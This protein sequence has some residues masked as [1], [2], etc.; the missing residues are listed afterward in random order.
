MLKVQNIVR[1]KYADAVA[2]LDTRFHGRKVLSGCV[3]VRGDN[4]QDAEVITVAT[5][6][7]LFCRVR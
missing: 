5:G 6:I 2:A 4:L 7:I 1:H 3:M